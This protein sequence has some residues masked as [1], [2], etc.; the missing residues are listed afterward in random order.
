MG[1]LTGPRLRDTGVVTRW[2]T[3]PE[4]DRIL[5]EV[6]ERMATLADLGRRAA[7]EARRLRRRARGNGHA[8]RAVDP[9]VAEGLRSSLAWFDA[10]GILVKGIDPPLVDF[11]ARLAGREVLLCWTEGEDRIAWHHDP[12]AGFD[13]RRPLDEAVP[14]GER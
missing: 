8:S 4:A 7:G 11:P 5:P 1:A 2:W 10:E 9:E 6:A 3:V 13:A 14:P 12:D